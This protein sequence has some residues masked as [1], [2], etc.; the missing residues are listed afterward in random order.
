MEVNLPEIFPCLQKEISLQKLEIELEDLQNNQ[1]FHDLVENIIEDYE[2]INQKQTNKKNQ[3]LFEMKNI[4]EIEDIKST[5]GKIYKKITAIKIP[6]GTV[7]YTIGM[8]PDYGYFIVH[9]CVELLRKKNN[10]EKL[11]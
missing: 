11:Q 1:Y 8:T 5:V 10:W 4:K 3:N 6:K 2:P 7:I 9:G